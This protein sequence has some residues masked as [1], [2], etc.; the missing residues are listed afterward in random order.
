MD[1]IT[2][3]MAGKTLKLKYLGEEETLVREKRVG[4]K[5]KVKKGDVFSCEAMQARGYMR[6]YKHLFSIVGGLEDT[7]EEIEHKEAKVAQRKKAS[8]SS[9]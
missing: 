6:A 7:K 8:K 5:I 1:F 2:K 4:E 9:K 3:Q